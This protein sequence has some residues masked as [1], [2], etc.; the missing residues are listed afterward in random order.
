[1]DIYSLSAEDAAGVAQVPGSLGRAL[2]ALEADHDFLRVG[3]VF[4]ESLLASYIEAKREEIDTVRLRP[5][6]MEY[7]LYYSI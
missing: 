2:D 3:G 6:P 5:H 7:E 4:G 1:M